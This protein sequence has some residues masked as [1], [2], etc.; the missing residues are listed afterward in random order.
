[1]KEC[2]TRRTVTRVELH[3]RADFGA[4]LGI[5]RGV[6]IGVVRDPPPIQ[7]SVASKASSVMAI[8]D[9]ATTLGDGGI[10]S[11]CASLAKAKACSD[12]I[13]SI[14]QAATATTAR[15]PILSAAI[16]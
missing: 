9:G 15:N 3:Y 13:I 11:V 10:V 5:I 12:G 2:E 7:E 8:S 6:T 16:I 1:V 14:K 4:K